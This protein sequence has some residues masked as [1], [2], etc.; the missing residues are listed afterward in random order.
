MADI[1]NIF[2]KIGVTPTQA[3]L[4]VGG[5]YTGYKILQKIGI[6][7]SAESKKAA[8]EKSEIVNLP[9]FQN[10]YWS[11]P[12]IKGKKVMLMTAATLLPKV[13]VLQGVKGF[14]NDNEDAL[15]GVLSSIK[16]RTQLAQLAQAFAKAS[17]KNLGS[18]L[19]GMT[20]A[21]ERSEIMKK[22]NNM[23]SGIL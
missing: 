8:E 7:S 4:T 16:Y 15:W 13:K 5:L 1:K 17:G 10:G 22:I 21:E 2:S 19:N 18:Y 6:V 11:L 12:N 14:F 9:E 3:A 23:E 20:N